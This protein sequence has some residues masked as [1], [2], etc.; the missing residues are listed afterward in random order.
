[1]EAL[2]SSTLAVA[3][4][5]IGD[6]T[7][8]LSLFLVSRFAGVRNAWLIVAGIVAA[9]LVNHA[10]SAWL[11]AWLATAIPENWLRW[12]VGASFIAI[13]AWLLIPDKDDDSE[14]G[15]LR[16]GAFLAT[17]VLFFIAEIGDKTQIATVVLAAKYSATVMVIIGT[18]LGMLLANVP[19][20]VAGGWI[21]ERVP[22]QWTRRAAFALFVALGVITIVAG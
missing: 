5:E 10:L 2:I 11:G 20:I 1:L 13:G 18:T 22:L 4:A 17:T 9:T 7:Q 8:L 3:I 21:M 6:K 14:S 12:L 19:V 16:Y 15:L